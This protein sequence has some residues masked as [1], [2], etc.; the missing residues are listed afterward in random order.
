MATTTKT[1]TPAAEKEELKL[2][3]KVTLRNIA[4][5][6]V[7]FDRVVEGVGTVRITPNGSTRLSRGEI[8]AQVQN[9]NKLIAGIDG[10]GGHATVYIDDEP[11]R[12]DLGFDKEDGTPQNM[13][14]DEKITKI[15]GIKQQDRFEETFKAEILTRAEQYATIQ[16]IQRLGIN[17]YA[18]IRFAERET[19][20]T[21]A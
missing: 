14:T 9:G 7:Y 12:K 18:K 17:D 1:A 8:I 11:T 13:L 2:D 20:Y 5:W 3:T 16:A 10:L 6:D 15:F 21:I 19:G 4:G